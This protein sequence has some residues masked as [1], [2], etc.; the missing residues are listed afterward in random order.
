MVFR[1]IDFTQVNIGK[2]CGNN[3]DQ[4]VYIHL[5][6]NKAERTGWSSQITFK[7]DGTGQYRY[8]I[9]VTQVNE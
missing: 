6:E 4:H 8:N 7:F 3:N 5:P 9:K 2:L 1:L